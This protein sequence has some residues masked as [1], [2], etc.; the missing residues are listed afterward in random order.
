MIALAQKQQQAGCVELPSDTW[1][2]PRQVGQLLCLY[3]CTCRGPQV[4]RLKVRAHRVWPTAGCAV[5]P[6]SLIIAREREEEEIEKVRKRVM[7]VSY[8]EQVYF[9]GSEIIYE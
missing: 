9:S 6:D 4:R 7:F 8:F 1:A 2:G 3:T 5:W